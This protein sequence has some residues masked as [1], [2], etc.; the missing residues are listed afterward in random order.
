MKIRK[1]RKGAEPS[2][3]EIVR[4]LMPVARGSLSLV[5]KSCNKPECNACKSGKGHPA[6]IFVYREDGRQRCRHVPASAAPLMKKAIENGRK[7][8]QAICAE[9]LRYLDSQQAALK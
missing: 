6:W 3:D 1:V 8:E 7:L 9:G 5:R 4:S 2:F